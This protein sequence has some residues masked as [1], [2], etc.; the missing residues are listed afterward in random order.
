VNGEDRKAFEEI[1]QEFRL[2]RQAVE[3]IE[4]RLGTARGPLPRKQRQAELS[5][6]ECRKLYKDI[7]EEYAQERTTRKLDALIARSRSDLSL[8][9]SIN[10]LPVDLHSAKAEIRSQILA[11]LREHE[12]L[13][14]TYPMPSQEAAYLADQKK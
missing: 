3:R 8:F 1:L 13:V 10:N 11:R 12:Q 6:I 4:T 2:L 14:A 7:G 9:C 5:E